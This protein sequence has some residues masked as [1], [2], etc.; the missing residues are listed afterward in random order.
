VRGFTGSVGPLC[1]LYPSKK[2]AH[3]KD[4]LTAPL[5]LTEEDF[6]YREQALHYAAILGQTAATRVPFITTENP[7]AAG[8]IARCAAHFA[9][10][11]LRMEKSWVKRP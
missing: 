2:A 6:I 7:D 11:Y 10:I 1:L 3:L 9:N 5:D 8:N 4:I